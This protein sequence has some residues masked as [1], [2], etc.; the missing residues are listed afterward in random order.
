MDLIAENN[1]KDKVKEAVKN[2]QKP[3]TKGEADV[4]F[5]KDKNEALDEEDNEDWMMSED[6]GQYW[7]DCIYCK[8][9][10][11]TNYAR[12]KHITMCKNEEKK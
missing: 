2:Q 11:K 3:D 7:C 4:A 10:F 1:S 5:S 9:F 12:N 8:M 6:E